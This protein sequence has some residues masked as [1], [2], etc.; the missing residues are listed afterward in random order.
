MVSPSYAKAFDPNNM[1]AGGAKLLYRVFQY[2]WRLC[3]FLPIALIQTNIL[4]IME[5]LLW[6]RDPDLISVQW[7][8]KSYEHWLQIRISDFIVIPRNSIL[9]VT[10]TLNICQNYFENNKYRVSTLHVN[11][12]LGSIGTCFEK[13]LQFSDVIRM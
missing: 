10:F 8:K 11:V 1:N 4:G 3:L 9:H 13:N 7:N 5:Q 2:Y 12:R 6:E